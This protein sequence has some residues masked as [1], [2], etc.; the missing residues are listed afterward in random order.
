MRNHSTKKPLPVSPIITILLT[1]LSIQIVTA[2][3]CE[4]YVQY[5]KGYKC[6]SEIPDKA[7]YG[8]KSFVVKPVDDASQRRYVISVYPM[9]YYS[10]FEIKNLPIL[11]EGRIVLRLKDYLMRNNE[12]IQ[13]KEYCIQG[14]I[15]T[16][17]VKQESVVCK[18]FIT[19]FMANLI[20]Q[21]QHFTDLHYIPTQINPKQICLFPK[22][23]GK[24][25]NLR[26]FKVFGTKMIPDGNPQYMPPEYI[27]ALQTKNKIT[28]D[29]K[30]VTYQLGYIF[31]FLVKAHDPFVVT[32]ARNEN[33][34]NKE[35]EFSF[36]DRKAFVDF[37]LKTICNHH[38]RMELVEVFRLFVENGGFDFGLSTLNNNKYYRLGDSILY[39]E[40]NVKKKTSFFM[41]GFVFILVVTGIGF[42]YYWCCGKEIK[43]NLGFE[44]HFEEEKAEKS[45]DINEG[46][47]EEEE[48][49]EKKDDINKGKEEES[50]KNDK[51]SP[52]TVNMG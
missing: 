7:I 24:L 31:Y 23:Q 20:G 21:I 36:N 33:I 46:D 2:A 38:L 19:R 15:Q 29:D 3:G 28:Y 6:L 12:F 40:S 47:G 11:Q 51:P 45:D 39:S 41:I 35:I 42:I 49:A 27:E 52:D 1:S 48:K 50:S 43:E 10:Q 17:L 4:D 37:I 30:F 14:S 13:L 44:E 34:W 16:K 18:V 5:F 9:D 26:G 25:N 8:P 22:S 32:G